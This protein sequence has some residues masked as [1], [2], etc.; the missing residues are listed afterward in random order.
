MNGF[1][2]QE[3]TKHIDLGMWKKLLKY[4]IPYKKYMA[5]LIC[6]MITVAGIDAILP[7][8]TSIAIDRFIVPAKLDGIWIY[9]LVFFIIVIIQVVCIYFHISIA[10]KIEVGI[11]SDIRDSAFRK[12]QELSLSYYDRTPVGWMMARLTSDTHRLGS[13]IAWGLVDSIWGMTMMLFIVVAMFALNWRL[14][15]ITMCVVPPLAIISVIF[16]RKILGAYRKVRRINSQIT[17]AFNEGIMGAKTSKTIVREEENLREFKGLTSQMYNSSVRAAIY[18]SVYMPIVLLLGSVGTSLVIWFGGD[19]V[20]LGTISYGIFV[21]F[22]NYSMRFFEPIRD[23]ARIFSELQYAQASGERVL[24]LIET[25]LDIKDDPAAIEQY[26]DVFSPKYDNWPPLRGNVVFDN[27]TFAYKNGEKVLE[28]FNLEVKQGER[29]ALVGETGSGKSTIVNLMCRFYEPTEG[30]ILV[31]G[32]D[33]REKSQIWLHSKL[34]Y[35]L[36][37]PHL[38]SGTIRDNIRYGK[39][40][41]SDDEVINAAKLVNAHEFIIKLENGYDTDV[42]EGGNKL[43]TG[44]KQ[45]VSFARAIIANPA[46]F[47][48]DEATSSIDTETEQFIQN[49]INVVLS[50]RTSFI[51]AHRLSTI[52]NADRILVLHDGKVIEEGTHNQLLKKKGRYYKLYT[53]QFLEEQTIKAINA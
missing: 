26:G 45:L 10:G 52:K 36:Q 20:I 23:L 3:Y 43:S 51:I 14:A 32:S 40:D 41:A 22:A 39:L 11:T 37:S 8:L 21:A 50:G 13:I 24:S 28:N 47:V 4:V 19:G 25:E 38:F 16:Q 15:L 31:D 30:R 34:G 46:I 18:S 35:V 1:E 7:L 42:G 29:I 6:L 27:V 53:N 9:A 12:L 17:G 5:I 44:Q 33:Y 2:E 48:L 49:A